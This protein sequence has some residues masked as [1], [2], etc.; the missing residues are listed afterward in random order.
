MSKVYKYEKE[1]DKVVKYE[2]VYETSEA[3]VQNEIELLEIIAGLNDD[4][5]NKI[6]ELGHYRLP[7]TSIK[8]TAI[9]QKSKKT[10]ELQK[11]KDAK[12]DK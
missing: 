4:V 5:I 2:V 11:V 1:G 3:Q 8:N 10:D 7:G 6:L 9:Y 12:K